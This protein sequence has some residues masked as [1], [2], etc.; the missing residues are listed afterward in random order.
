MFCAQCGNPL[1]EGA[2][3]C[4]NCGAPAP[5]VVPSTPAAVPAAAVVAGQPD[6][7]ADV[8][9]EAPQIVFE[10]PPD[11]GPPRLMPSEVPSKR[12]P[13]EP[14]PPPEPPA[15]GASIACPRCLH[16]IPAGRK[17]CTNCGHNLQAPVAAPVPPVPPP[18]VSEPAARAAPDDAPPVAVARKDPSPLR[19]V[20]IAGF[21]VAVL[22][23]FLAWATF[24]GDSVNLWNTDGGGRYQIADWAGEAQPIDAVFVLV[25]AL[26]GGYLVAAPLIGGSAPRVPFGAAICG[27]AITAIAV[28]NYPYLDGFSDDGLDIGI[29]LYVTV[30]AAGAAAISAFMVEQQQRAIPPPA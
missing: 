8:E 9:E 4:P 28:A 1:I 19:M 26:A 6:G 30:I 7:L 11:S 18:A 13:A 5:T 23:T 2:R 16:A 27:A 29:G 25:I 12:A 22:A 10:L 14:V 20:A 21:A 17:F 24:E 3:F 15:A